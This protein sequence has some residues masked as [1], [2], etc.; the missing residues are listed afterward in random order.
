MYYNLKNKNEGKW[1]SKEAT[2]KFRIKRSTVHTC[3]CSR[4]FIKTRGEDQ[5]KC[6]ACILKNPNIK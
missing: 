1:G 3:K 2:Y 4:K 6:L 5:S